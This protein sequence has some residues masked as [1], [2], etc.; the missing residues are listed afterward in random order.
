MRQRRIP[1]KRRTAGRVVRS[2]RRFIAVRDIELRPTG[3]SNALQSSKITK[4]LFTDS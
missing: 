1:S 4:L 2:K 3:P